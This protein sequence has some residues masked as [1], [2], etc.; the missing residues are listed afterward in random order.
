M[1]AAPALRLK[2]NPL[3]G[4]RHAQTHL[5]SRSRPPCGPRGRKHHPAAR[6]PLAHGAPYIRPGPIWDETRRSIQS[7]GREPESGRH[8][9]PLGTALMVIHDRV[10]RLDIDT[11][12]ILTRSG[13]GVRAT[14]QDVEQAYPGQI[15]AQPHPSTG[16]EGHYLIFV[17]RDA[18]DSVFGIIFETDCKQV[19]QYRA[20]REPAVG[21]IEGCS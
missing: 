21:Y 13:I 16:P 11:T 10:E 3:G 8:A 15:R 19:T 20:G 1:A 17:P 6:Q 9:L 4:T 18:Q 14:E 12:G 7:T 5:S 2:R